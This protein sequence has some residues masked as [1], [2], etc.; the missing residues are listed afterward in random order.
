M[1]D[2][3]GQSAT[4]YSS[5][6]LVKGAGALEFDVSQISWAGASSGNQPGTGATYFVTFEFWQHTV[7]GDYVAADSYLND[8]EKI[9]TAP[10]GTWNLRDCID[11]RTADGVRPV[12]DETPRFD[13]EYYLSRID[14]VAL[15][16]DAMFTRIAGVAADE[17]VKPSGQADTMNIF[18]VKVPPYTYS[19]GDVTVTSLQM[20]RLP[21]IALNEL[22]ASQDNLKYY[23]AQFMAE[24]AAT[25]NTAA[26][27]AQGIIVDSLTGQGRCDVAFNKNGVAFTAAIDAKNRQLRLPVT[28]DGTTITLDE[29]N[30]TGIASVGKVVMFDY[31]ETPY[32]QQLKAT[33][34]MNV[35]PYAVY[36]WIGTMGLD[37]ESDYWSDVEQLPDVDVNYENELAALEEIEAENAERALK[38]TWGSWSRVWDDSGGW[39][40]KQLQSDTDAHWSSTYSSSNSMGSVNAERTRTGT[41]TTPGA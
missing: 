1:N 23:I 22:K 4:Q 26:A 5:Y 3:A 25:S 17:P 7:E 32:I 14:L 9:E 2:S 15:R 38:I 10:N 21:Q 12:P 13:L 6:A 8:Y 37:P 39:A 29:A 27:D 11:F 31:E 19:P 20:M 33:E 18:L 35:N 16:S 28:P 30:S 41:Y 34:I 36:G 24:Q 40:E